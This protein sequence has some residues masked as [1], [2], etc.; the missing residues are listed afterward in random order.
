MATAVLLTI[1]SKLVRFVTVLVGFG[2]MKA[3]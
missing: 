2:E 3:L 1:N